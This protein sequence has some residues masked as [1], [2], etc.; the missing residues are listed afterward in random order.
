MYVIVRELRHR[1]HHH[2]KLLHARNILDDVKLRSSDSHV[3][4]EMQEQIISGAHA[5]NVADRRISCAWICRDHHMTPL[6]RFHELPRYVALNNFMR[7]VPSHRV[8]T[9]T[10]DLKAL[11]QRQTAGLEADVHEPGAREVSVSEY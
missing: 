8:A 1:L 10:I 2:R 11:L 5:M 3:T 7:E 6:F 9:E 4:E